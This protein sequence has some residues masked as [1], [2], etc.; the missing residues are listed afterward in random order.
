LIDEEVRRLID[1]A[2]L[3]ARK[4]LE[5]CR[6]DLDKVATALL[7]YE[8]LSGDEVMALLRGEP[9]VRPDHDDEPKDTGRRASVPSSGKKKDQPHGGFGPKPQPES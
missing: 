2:E 3:S 6:D 9:V 7:E 1:E 8:T 4:I 5:E